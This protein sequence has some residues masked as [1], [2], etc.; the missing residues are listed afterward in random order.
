MPSS[1][2]SQDAEQLLI[3]DHR[4]LDALYRKLLVSLDQGDVKESLA[5]LDIFWARLAMHIRSENL[6]LFPAVLGALKSGS[7]EHAKLPLPLEEVRETV[8]Q[9]REDH[10][11]FM[12]EL[13]IAVNTMREA[14]FE[15][16]V[17]EPTKRLSSARQGII[18]VGNRLVT[19]NELEEELIYPCSMTLLDASE[20]TNLEKQVRREIENL[21]PRLRVPESE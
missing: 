6:H 8:A 12:R 4:T 20:Q 13:A 18:S 15:Q 1:E 5:R 11:F 2:T 19:H 7:N 3:E 16:P 9:L 21:P 14:L 17:Q 10:A